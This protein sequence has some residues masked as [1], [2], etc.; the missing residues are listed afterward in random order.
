MTEREEKNRRLAE[1]AGFRFNV[2]QWH[3]PDCDCKA[4]GPETPCNCVDGC[5]IGLE[6]DAPDFFASESASFILL[7]MMPNPQLWLES[8]KDEPKLWGC[9]AD[10]TGDAVVGYAHDPDPLAAIAEAALALIEKGK[11]T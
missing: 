8:T 3:H 2:D 6:G 5:Y 10:Y 11:R 4:C 1:W 9:W 7:K